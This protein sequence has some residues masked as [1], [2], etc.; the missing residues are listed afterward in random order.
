MKA[1]MPALPVENGPDERLR[2]WGTT[3]IAAATA[4]WVVIFGAVRLIGALV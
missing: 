3:L 4:S 2:H 1:Q